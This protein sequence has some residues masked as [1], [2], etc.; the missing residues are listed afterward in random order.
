MAGSVDLRGLIQ[1]RED[2]R[3]L[4][5]GRRDEREKLRGR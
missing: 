2:V 5:L 4:A 3:A 1:P